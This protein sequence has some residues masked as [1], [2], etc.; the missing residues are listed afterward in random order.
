MTQSQAVRKWS[1]DKEE[2]GRGHVTGPSWLTRLFL[3]CPEQT[4]LAFSLV[5]GAVSPAAGRAATHSNVHDSGPERGQTSPLHHI[6]VVAVVVCRVSL[7][8]VLEVVGQHVVPVVLLL[9]SVGERHWPVGLDLL[10]RWVVKGHHILLGNGQQL[11]LF[12]R[13]ILGLLAEERGKRII[14]ERVSVVGPLALHRGC[15][16]ILSSLCGSNVSPGGWI[17]FDLTVY[18]E[19]SAVRLTH[20]VVQEDTDYG[21]HHTQDICQSDWVAQHKKWDANNHDPLGG[22]GDS[23]AEWADKVQYAEGD[24]ILSKVAEPADEQEEKCTRWS[25]NV[26]L[27]GEKNSHKAG[28]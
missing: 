9:C 21:R 18:I 28:S 16:L 6:L 20:L 13:V 15:P 7:S 24:D 11:L 23:V 14:N 4:A 3:P 19:I 10:Q 12:V 25:W 22:V 17:K 26:R 5:G 2:R 8:A 1:L 27:S